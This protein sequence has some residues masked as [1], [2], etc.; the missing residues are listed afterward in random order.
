MD[1]GAHILFEQEVQ[2]YTTA[3]ALKRP[4]F[5]PALA[6]ARA[7][8]RTIPEGNLLAGAVVGA[9]VANLLAALA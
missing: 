8:A 9:H 7:T 1:A 3:W 6:A 2:I 5:L 4:H